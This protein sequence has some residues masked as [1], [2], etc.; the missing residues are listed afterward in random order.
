MA[1][2]ISL[3]LIQFKQQKGLYYQKQ[4]PHTPRR[5]I[6]KNSKPA[7]ISPPLAAL[8]AVAAGLRN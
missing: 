7:R 1:T 4:P 3:S 6:K 2:K 5:V 8:R